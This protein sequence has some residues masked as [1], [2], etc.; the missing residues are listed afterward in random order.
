MNYLHISFLNSISQHIYWNTLGILTQ[1]LHISFLHF[2]NWYHHSVYIS[3][4][5]LF[6][7]SKTKNTQITGNKVITDSNSIDFF[8][9][10]RNYAKLK[11]L[12]N[13]IH[14]KVQYP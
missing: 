13:R 10:K 6:N 5:F 2:S 9:I 4:L 11:K 8:I 1:T 12:K 14:T 7:L 3:N